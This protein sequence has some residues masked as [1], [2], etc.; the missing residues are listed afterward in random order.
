MKESFITEAEKHTEIAG[1][2]D[3]IVAGS[4][5]SGFAAAVTAARNG[6]KTLIISLPPT[7]PVLWQS[8]RRIFWRLTS[9]RLSR[10]YPIE[11]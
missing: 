1:K 7:Q 4:G 11:K 5:P 6:A 9:M 3:V 10:K 8:M 2:Y